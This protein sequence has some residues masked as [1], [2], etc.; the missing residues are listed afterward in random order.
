[1]TELVPNPGSVRGTRVATPS[2]IAATRRAPRPVVDLRPP[3][4]PG[5]THVGPHRCTR[6]RPS[7]NTMTRAVARKST[8]YSGR[9]LSS[10][11]VS[12]NA[13]RA[14]GGRSDSSGLP[15][16][17]AS[18]CAEKTAA[19]NAVT[20]ARNRGASAGVGATWASASRPIWPAASRIVRSVSIVGS[21]YRV[22][23]GKTTMP[24][25]TSSPAA[26]TRVASTRL[27]RS[28]EAASSA[29][30]SAT[31]IS[32]STDPPP[33]NTR[34]K[35]AAVATASAQTAPSARRC[36]PRG[37]EPAS[38]AIRPSIGPRAGA[39]R[40]PTRNGRA[41]AAPGR[42]GPRAVPAARAAGCRGRR[43][44]P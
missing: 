40:R 24:T 28:S 35:A 29:D 5:H 23:F 25:T 15:A 9:S 39:P 36:W 26:L 34:P 41:I 42:R 30:A 19:H 3:R 14:T 4:A 18:A 8:P 13:T 12:A 27:R 31:P 44:R 21:P 6:R 2:A 22:V 20:A 16:R 10:S 7:M 32:R 43:G 37:D 38:C 11:T 17:I 1:M 33:L